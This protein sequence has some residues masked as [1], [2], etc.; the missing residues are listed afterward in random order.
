MGRVSDAMLKAPIF[1]NDN[2][3]LDFL[4]SNAGQRLLDLHT[5]AEVAEIG[6]AHAS[7]IYETNLIELANGRNA[8]KGVWA[9]RCR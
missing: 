9:I 8:N 1:E 4:C 5:S 7:W 6:G 2:I 3:L